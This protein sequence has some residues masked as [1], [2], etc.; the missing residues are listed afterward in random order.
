MTKNKIFT[1]QLLAATI[2]GFGAIN[3]AQAEFQIEEVVVTAQKRAQSVNDIGV[4][5]SAFGGDDLKKLNIESAVDLGAHTPGLVTANATSGGT[6]MP[7]AKRSTSESRTA[8]TWAAAIS[9]ER[10]KR[11]RM[12]GPVG[13]G[14]RYLR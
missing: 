6:P 7:Q 2:A 5:A 8:F 10:T 12:P 13:A 11:E 1:R 9:S 4:S 14:T 3:V